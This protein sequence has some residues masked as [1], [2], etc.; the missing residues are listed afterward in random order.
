MTLRE[1]GIVSMDFI[2]VRTLETETQSVLAILRR[3]GELILTN[4]GQPSVYVIDLEGQDLVDVVNTFR[5]N[6][7]INE[8]LKASDQ[9]M[10]DPNAKWLEHFEFWDEVRQL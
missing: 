9:R 1:R 10:A 2:P 4:N 6:R 3:D 5:H 7:Y 8:K